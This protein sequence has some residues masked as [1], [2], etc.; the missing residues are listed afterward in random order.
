LTLRS[1]YDTSLLH[2]PLV[3]LRKIDLKKMDQATLAIVG[4]AQLAFRYPESN[5]VWF[6]DGYILND[7]PRLSEVSK[8]L[9]AATE[10]F[11]IGRTDSMSI[12]ADELSLTQA[13]KAVKGAKITLDLNVELED[14]PEV[15]EVETPK[16][17]KSVAAAASA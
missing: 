2:N 4:D 1:T 10:H 3:V 13:E 15:E 6:A 8:E 17:K 5:L 7:Q 11:A 14:E 16:A 12:M 9:I